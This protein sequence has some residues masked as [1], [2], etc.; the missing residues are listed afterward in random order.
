[1]FLLGLLLALAPLPQTTNATIQPDLR[2]FTTMAALNAAGFD[3]EFGSEY[4]PVREAVRRYAKEI[5]P[6]LLARLKA[7]YGS[8]KGGE[9][10]DAQL[11]KYVSLAVSISDPPAFKPVTREEILPPDA[12]SVIGF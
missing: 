1:M 4:H 3:V 10:D 6:D 8:H 7:F 9:G 2:L 5:D 12:R 11:A